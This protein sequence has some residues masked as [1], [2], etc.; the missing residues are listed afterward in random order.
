MIVPV[1]PE[2]KYP[3]HILWSSPFVYNKVFHKD[4]AKD[5]YFFVCSLSV[6]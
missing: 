3:G 4:F 5:N 2:V 6:L 1:L